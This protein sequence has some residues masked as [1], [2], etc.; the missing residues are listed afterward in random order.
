MMIKKKLTI[1]NILM[2][3]IPVILIFSIAIAIRTPI[4]KMYE[5]NMDGADEFQNGPHFVQDMFY[6][7]EFTKVL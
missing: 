1:S 4:M 3:I 5:K 2:L 6:L 7:R